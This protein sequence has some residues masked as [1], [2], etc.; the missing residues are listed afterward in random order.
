MIVDWSCS[1]SFSF[2]FLENCYFEF[3]VYF[4]PKT[5]ILGF[6][7]FVKTLF[8]LFSFC[9][10]TS[11]CQIVCCFCF[12]VS[13]DLIHDC[14]RTDTVVVGYVLCGEICLIDIFFAVT[15]QVWTRKLT[16]EAVILRVWVRRLTF[17]VV[18]LRVKKRIPGR[19]VF[20]CYIWSDLL[21]WKLWFW[22][23]VTSTAVK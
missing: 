16:F 8:F 9:V 13:E 2:F 12:L 11:N 10:F 20:M 4:L 21:I 18:L 1:D 5:E 17:Q 23:Y 6:A 15:L 22:F 14:S 7:Y 19:G 3:V